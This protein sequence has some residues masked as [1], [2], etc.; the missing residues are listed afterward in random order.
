MN[1][2]QIFYVNEMNGI[3]FYN[4]TMRLRW[5]GSSN[6]L[7]KLVTSRTR[8]HKCRKERVSSHQQ[9]YVI[10][11]KL[12]NTHA[13]TRPRTQALII[14]PSFSVNTEEACPFWKKTV[15]RQWWGVDLQRCA[16]QCRSP[17][18]EEHTC[19][20]GPWNMTPHRKLT[21]DPR[22]HVAVKWTNGIVP[23]LCCHLEYVKPLC[24]TSR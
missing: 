17:D 5:K 12:R 3:P 10:L 22:V 2:R 18:R 15:S 4:R 8:K 14:V 24:S 23:C 6:L 19:F 1:G 16:G 13:H 21:V 7:W 11:H 9:R 20:K